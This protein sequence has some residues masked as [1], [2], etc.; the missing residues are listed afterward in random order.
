M[1]GQLIQPPR[2]SEDRP[3]RDRLTV[4][5]EQ[6]K[7]TAVF[8]CKWD[9]LGIEQYFPNRAWAW[10]TNAGSRF[11][12]PITPET[13]A[14]GGSKHSLSSLRRPSHGSSSPQLFSPFSNS[15][16]IYRLFMISG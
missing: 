13:A 4:R 10:R 6:F 9:Q 11:I 14:F 8:G 3:D 2:R 7:K 15:R 16:E 1:A 12:R 5:F